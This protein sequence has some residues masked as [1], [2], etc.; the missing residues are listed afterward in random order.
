MPFLKQIEQLAEQ[1]RHNAGAVDTA[2]EVPSRQLRQLA[3]LGYF[4]RATTAA[5]GERR[6]WL[7]RL[8]SGCGVTS[9]LATQHSGACRR[10]AASQHP[11]LEK[12]QKGEHWVGVCFAHLRRPRCPVLVEENAERLTFSGRGP[13]FSG[14]GL[15]DHLLVGGATDQGVYY[16]AHTPLRHPSIKVGETQPLAVMNATA[17]VPL[18][19]DRLPVPRSEVVVTSNAKHMA[20]QDM[21][22]TV[23]QSSRSLG[24]A[25][26]A[27]T[28]LPG[29]AQE[30]LL[31]RLETQ[32]QKMDRWD[33]SPS[34][35]SASALRMEAIELAARSVQA[36]FMSVGGRAHALAHPVQRLAREASFYST[37]QLTQPLKETSLEQL[38]NQ[39]GEP[40]VET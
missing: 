26:A 35:P 37:T 39:C 36:A 3:D 20:E 19:F 6:R 5:P 22:S 14:L 13:W 21:H 23:Y 8:A 32:H 12:A 11:L 40:H 29:S 9:F 24:V 10:L 31:A 2:T 27:A 28:F 34:W 4:Q 38:I 25:R 17:T 1:F 18:E 16:L 33:Q 7:D 30:S 15:L